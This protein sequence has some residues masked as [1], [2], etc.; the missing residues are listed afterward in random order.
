MA[1]IYAKSTAGRVHNQKIEAKLV[2]GNAL[3]DRDAILETIVREYSA[4]IAR[5]ANRLLGWPGEVDDIVQDV[6]VSAYTGLKKFR[7]EC[8]IKGWL[9]TITINKCRSYRYKK[10]LRFKFFEKLAGSTSFEQT[11]NLDDKQIKDETF[12]DVRRA[13]SKLPAKYREAVVLKYLQEMKTSDITQILGIKENTLNVR[14]NRA[15]GL[16]EKKLAYL[17]KE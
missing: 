8:D 14:L 15:R 11:E 13:V 17:M 12:E 4:D 5:L 3:L 6:F 9:F 1:Q 16:L 10:M 7:Y 2:I